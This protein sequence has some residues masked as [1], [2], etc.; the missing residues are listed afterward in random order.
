MIPSPL[1]LRPDDSLAQAAAL[2]RG[3]QLRALPIVDPKGRLEG[4]LFKSA[5]AAATHQQVGDVM[6]SN[7]RSLD[8]ETSFADLMEYCSR[9]VTALIVIVRDGR[10]TGFV[11]PSQLATLTEPLTTASFAPAEVCSTTSRYLRVADTCAVDDG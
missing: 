8:E 11:S 3:S 5:V 7:V 2:F 1:V 9:E 4:I 6:T 10:P